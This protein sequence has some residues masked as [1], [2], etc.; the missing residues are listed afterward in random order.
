MEKILKEKDKHG[1]FFMKNLLQIL[2]LKIDFLLHLLDTLC[3]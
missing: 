3:L 1:L 2:Q